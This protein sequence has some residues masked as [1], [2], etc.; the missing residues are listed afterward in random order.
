MVT[1]IDVACCL[2]AVGKRLSSIDLEDLNSSIVERIW[3]ASL[4]AYGSE[5]MRVVRPVV[6]AFPLSFGADGMT[7]SVPRSYSAEIERAIDGFMVESSEFKSFVNDAIR[8]YVLIWGVSTEDENLVRAALRAGADPDARARYKGV[9]MTSLV[10][11]ATA[12]STSICKMLL[13]SGANPNIRKHNSET[14]L[15]CAANYGHLEICELLLAAGANPNAKTYAGT[16]LALADGSK[17]VRLLLEHGADPN[18]PDS[19]GDIPVIGSIDVGNIEEIDLLINYGTDMEHAN[20]EGETPMDRAKKRGLY[21]T[22]VKLIR[23]AGEEVSVS[24]PSRLS[25]EESRAVLPRLSAACAADDFEKAMDLLKEGA[26]PNEMSFEGRAPVHYCNEVALVCLL[27]HFGANINA[28]DGFGNTPLIN[29]CLRDGVNSNRDRAITFLIGAGADVDMKNAKGL[30]AKDIVASSGNRD[31]FAAL[32]RGVHIVEADRRKIESRL[33]KQKRDLEEWRAESRSLEEADSWEEAITCCFIAC[34]LSDLDMLKSDEGFVKD[35]LSV[36]VGFSGSNVCNML[37]VACENAA[38]DV[39]KY[40]ISLGVDVNQVDDTGQ[41]ALRYA[42]ISWRDASEKI[43]ALIEAGADVNHRC[44]DGSAAL[45]DAAFAQ[46]VEAA[47][48]L[49]ANGAD[50]GNRDARGYTAISWTCGKGVPGSE[51][52][53]LLLR[54]GADVCDLY[55]MDC[56]LQYR[57]YESDDFF[58]RTNDVMLRPQDL[59]E[60][61]LYEFSLM[62]V[63]VTAHGKQKL[64]SQGFSF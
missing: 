41:T 5:V 14:P 3:D 36:T 6:S 59:K 11:S 39:V 18:I 53:E 23:S 63:M 61:H 43:D 42:A 58:L 7:Y 20:A 55:N 29:F 33:D 47:K 52:V 51:I 16:P 35:N 48:A 57:D 24:G 12:G 40:L 60:R 50:V 26:D 1:E 27:E 19:D 2:G 46:N 17:I 13:D 32:E 10:D 28:I 15:A 4:G 37:M 34:A 25:A 38:I 30:S 8:D 54:H 62:P 22:V 31:A 56:V 21:E 9:L 64:R 45:S 44:D 49:I